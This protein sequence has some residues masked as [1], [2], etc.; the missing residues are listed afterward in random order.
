MNEELQQG[1]IDGRYQMLCPNWSLDTTVPQYERMD[2][3]AYAHVE[4]PTRGN[5][6]PLGTRDSYLVEHDKARVAQDMANHPGGNARHTH[7][8]TGAYH[9]GH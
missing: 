7:T 9:F 3:P 1:L 6:T 8:D 2:W 4:R 5:R